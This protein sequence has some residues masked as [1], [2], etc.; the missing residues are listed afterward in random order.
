MLDDLYQTGLLVH[1]GAAQRTRVHSACSSCVGLLL[2]FN[3]FIKVILVCGQMAAGRRTPT[4]SAVLLFLL[5]NGAP[6]DGQ[7]VMVSGAVTSSTS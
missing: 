6:S 4:I 2:K 7:T 5:I 1:D 3:W